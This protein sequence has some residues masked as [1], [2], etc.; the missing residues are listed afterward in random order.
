MSVLHER[1][2]GHQFERRD[3]ELL[4]MLDDRLG[5]HARISAA[6]VLRDFRMHFAHTANM[7][8]VD[9]SLVRRI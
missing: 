7:S 8:F 6:Q 3:P 1:V 5:R 4:Q 9:Q 2:H